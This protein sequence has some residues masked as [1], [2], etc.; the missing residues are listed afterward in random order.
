MESAE[1]MG[2]R[3]Q[4]RTSRNRRSLP[5]LPVKGRR[6]AEMGLGALRVLYCHV[7]ATG[8]RSAAG[9]LVA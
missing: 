1:D 4:S 3:L 9:D 5:A 7:L 8:K 2:D 6:K